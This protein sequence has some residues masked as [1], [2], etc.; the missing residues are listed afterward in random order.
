MPE[1]NF[2]SEDA[3]GQAALPRVSEQKPEMLLKWADEKEARPISRALAASTIRANRRQ[4]RELRVK[5]VRRHG[6]TY[7]A[8]DFLGIGCVIF[9]AKATGSQQ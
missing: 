2:Y 8:S 1:M 6:E 3:A 9:R 5:V 7:I 4:P